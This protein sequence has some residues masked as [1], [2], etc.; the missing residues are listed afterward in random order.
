MTLPC[1]ICRKAFGRCVFFDPEGE[2]QLAC[3]GCL[4]ELHAGASAPDEPGA[5]A[6]CV[7][8]GAQEATWWVFQKHEGFE[9]LCEG[10]CLRAHLFGDW[11]GDDKEE[12]GHSD[13]R[14]GC[15][16]VLSTF[17]RGF[18]TYVRYILHRMPHRARTPA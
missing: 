7:A 18:D 5:E 16:I 4:V 8:C 12:E 13:S 1:Q 3:V 15:R 11:F 2:E 9:H 6:E 14:S 10:C 17:W